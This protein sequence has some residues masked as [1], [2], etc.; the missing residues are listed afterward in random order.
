MKLFQECRS[1]VKTD[2]DILCFVRGRPSIELSNGLRWRFREDESQDSAR[3]MLATTAI[4]GTRLRDTIFTL[5][6]A[7]AP[8]IQLDRKGLAMTSPTHDRLSRFTG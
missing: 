2:Y 1:N 6:D 3:A 7:P 8:A 4:D 5:T